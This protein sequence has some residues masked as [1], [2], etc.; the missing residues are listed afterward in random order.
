M[1][2]VKES[3]GRTND[4]QAVDAFI[5]ENANGMK[6]KVINYGATIVS[7]ETPDRAGQPADLVCGF[8]DMVGY[9]SEANP[10]FGACCGRYANRIAKGKFTLDGVEYSLAINNGPNGLHGG[11]VGFD[12]K[13]WDA[14]MVG[15]S[16]KMTLIS[17][18][19]EEGYPGTLKVELTY[20]LNDEGELRLDYSATTDQKTILNLTNH[21]Y[22]NLAG[23]A[24][25]SV[26][27]QIICINADRYTEVDDD[28]TPSGRL[29]PVAGTEMD[30]T[31]PTPIGQRIGEVQGRGY[32]HNYCLNKKAEGELSL[33]AVVTDP[34]SGRAM[35]CWTTEPG[36]QFYAANWVENVVGKGGAIYNIQESFCLEAQHYPDSPNHPDFPSTELAPGETYTQTTIYKFGVEG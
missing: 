16:V 29:L 28:A 19:G 23:A 10:Y 26:H 34:A 21:S 4:G 31:S 11:T 9:Q 1:S 27:D 33:A 5:F 32:D 7:I 12:K 17:P 30:L 24:S 14:A 6:A 20:S 36:V 3:F 22:F 25:G 13:V 35:E 8:D 15:D 18:D 2:V